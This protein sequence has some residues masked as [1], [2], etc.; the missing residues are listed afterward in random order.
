MID[1]ISL[2]LMVGPMVPVPVPKVVLD[3]LTDVEVST[4]TQG[5][6]AFQLRFS[7]STRSPLHTL[8]MLSGGAVAPI[9]RVILIVTMRG[10][11][12]V[13]IDGVIT[14]QDVAPG[15]ELGRSVLTIRGED[16]TRVMDFVEFTGFPY[17]AMPPEA[18]IALIIAKYAMF[19]MIPLVIPSLFTEAPIPV[20]RIPAHEGTDL[21]YLEQL[22]RDAG[23][24][25]FIDPGPAPGTNIAYW[26]PE[27]K[28][29]I[30]Q[31]ALNIDMDAHANVE[32]LSFSFES[33]STKL[34]IVW[35]QNPQTR[36]S[37]PIPIP[38][39]SPLN[40][41]L[42]LLSAIPKEIEVL[43]GTAGLSP[44]RAISRGL[45]EASRSSDTVT[46]TGTLDVLSYGRVLKA[47]QL[48]GVRGAGAPFDGLHYVSS[49]THRIK[50]GEYKQSFG[51]TRNGLIST[52]PQVPV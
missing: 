43:A 8:L 25:F 12:S 44:T 51:L 40:P 18:R 1:G 37:I 7:L 49:V 52:L 5:P 33:Q 31:P 42:G 3:A 17:P 39:I 22:A 24:V 46:G 14:E 20:D 28:V 26:G 41:P 21:D 48:V 47:R 35:Y 50:R 16:L 30:P 36:V 13:L 45:A 34:P 15:S 4:S 27:I 9:M 19:G 10:T 6:S 32:S 29:G 11:P 2:T 38:D 23:Y